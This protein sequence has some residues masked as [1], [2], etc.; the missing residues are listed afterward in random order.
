M[1]QI[2]RFKQFTYTLTV[3][4]LSLPLTANAINP[5]YIHKGQTIGEIFQEG[6]WR[7]MFFFKI[8]LSIYP[9]GI[10]TLV[11]PALL[12]GY[13]I[14]RKYIAWLFFVI[15][16]IIFLYP[17]LTNKT[18]KLSDILLSNIPE[19]FLVVLITLLAFFASTLLNRI[20]K[21]KRDFTNRDYIPLAIVIAIPLFLMIAPVNSGHLVCDTPIIKEYFNCK[22]Y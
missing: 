1:T 6:F 16:P 11:I 2:Q 17:I 5:Y 9:F 3:A 7:T 12:I 22:Y 19:L 15:Y 10:L 20:R 14:H 18:S 21:K 8:A 4:L 13:F